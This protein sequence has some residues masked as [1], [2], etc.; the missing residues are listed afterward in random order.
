MT[1]LQGRRNASGVAADAFRPLYDRTDGKDGYVSLE[2][3][4]QHRCR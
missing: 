3:N 4:P 2:V 1:G